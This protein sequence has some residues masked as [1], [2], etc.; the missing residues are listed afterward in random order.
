LSDKID[1]QSKNNA[2]IIKKCVS[3]L[4][5]ASDFFY[6]QKKKA[7]KKRVSNEEAKIQVEGANEENKQEENKQLV[8]NEDI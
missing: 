8:N 3:I 2:D 7:Q 5:L 4:K 1:I 6:N